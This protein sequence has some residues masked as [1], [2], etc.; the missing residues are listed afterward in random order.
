VLVALVPSG[1]DGFTERDREDI[2]RALRLADSEGGLP[3]SVY[4]GPLGDDSR[5]RALTLHG[6]LSD[7]GHG[8]LVAVDPGS[9]RVEVVTGPESKRYLDDRGAT[10]GVLAMTTS[11][12]AGDLAGGIVNGLRTLSEHARH[13]RVL[14]LDQP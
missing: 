7:P 2:R 11:L 13:P 1:E 3:F 10:L 6:A 14:H 4:V 9:R 12:T 8:V 5:A